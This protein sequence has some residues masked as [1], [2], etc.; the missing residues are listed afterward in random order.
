[1]EL[2]PTLLLRRE[3]LIGNGNFAFYIL[4]G[5]TNDKFYN[6]NKVSLFLRERFSL[7]ASG[8]REFN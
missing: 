3:G 1:M 4:T 7:P 8:W 2:N 6:D 5:Q